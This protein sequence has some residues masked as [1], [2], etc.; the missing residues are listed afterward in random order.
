[1]H[2][3]SGAPPFVVTTGPA[4]PIQIVASGAPPITLFNEDGSLWAGAG[5]AAVGGAALLTG[6]TDGFATDFLYATD[7]QRVALKTGGSTL[8]YAVD[9]FYANAGTSPKMVYDAAGVLGWSPHNI[10]LQ[11]QT[12]DS[13]TWVPVGGLTVAGNVAVAPDGTM[14]ADKLIEGTGAGQFRIYQG[15]V[16]PV[17]CVSIYVKAAGRSQLMFYDGAAVKFF[18]FDL[19]TATVLPPNTAGA[20]ITAVGNGWYRCV[21]PTLAGAN[22]MFGIASGGTDAITG[23]GVSG[24]Y[25]WGAQLNNGPTALAYLP[26]TSAARFGLALDYDPVT[27]AAKGLLCEPQ[28]TNLVIQSSGAAFATSGAS[29]TE[30]TTASPTGSVDADTLTFTTAGSVTYQTWGAVTAGNVFTFSLFAKTASGTK[31]FKMR[32]FDGTTP[33]FSPELTATTTWQRFVLTATMGVT[34]SGTWSLHDDDANSGGS[35]IIWGKQVEAGTVAT[36]PIPTLAATVTRAADQVN[37]TSASIN[38]SATAGSWWVE[39]YLMGGAL[40]EWIIGS[41]TVASPM[42]YNVG[43]VVIRDGTQVYIPPGPSIINN[44]NKLMSAFTTG[45]R[46]ITYNG[47]APATDAGTVTN[48]LAQSYI[49]FGTSVGASSKM[50]GYIRKL[51]YLPRDP[52]GAEMQTMTT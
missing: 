46:A 52:S 38:Y 28:A 10:A 5:G 51:R 21:A 42:F 41:T 18:Y 7:A 32:L 34:G 45:R 4:P 2:V 30:D 40:D 25:V 9:A 8:A 49:G 19:P 33:Y 20:S 22:P 1:V 43:G 6:E 27:H 36:S 15:A 37:V 31:K 11:S 17:G 16:D 14:T 3:P 23:D 50:N 24:L 39:T 13:G 44:I 35:V 29:W 47:Q 12:F 48:I 26:T